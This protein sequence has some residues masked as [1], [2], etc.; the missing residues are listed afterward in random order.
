M[1]GA[2]LFELFRQRAVQAGATVERLSGPREAC[3]YVCRL[4][5]ERHLTPVLVASG[6]LLGEMQ[7]IT[8]LVARGVEVL[9]EA[10]AGVQRAALGVTEA[11]LGIAETG[12]LYQDA[13]ALLVRLASMLP[14]VHVA[15]LP[16]D[17]IVGTLEEAL[18]HLA[19]RGQP[20]GYAA[21]ITGPSRT[22]DIERVLTIGV[23]GPAEL[24]I[25]CIDQPHA[26]QR[27]ASA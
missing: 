25:L 10:G 5:E 7:L 17:R 23:H 22:A 13:T 26:A 27:A 8:A 9:L 14:P 20:P 2:D 18:P 6:P 21:L 1:G 12:S 16:S 15:V 11:D 24:R 3:A 4:V 19:C